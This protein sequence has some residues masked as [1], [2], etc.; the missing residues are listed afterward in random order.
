MNSNGSLK[1]ILIIGPSWLGDMVMAQSLFKHILLNHNYKVQLDVL[2]PS[3]SGTLLERMPEVN[4]YI[5]LNLKHGELGLKKRYLIGKQLR[6]KNYTEAVILP[7]SWKSA[8]I[9]FIAEIPKRIG[10]VGEHRFGLINDIRFLNKK[11][12][13]KMIE[14]YVALAYPPNYN[15]PD[16]LLPQLSVDLN[17]VKKLIEQP[18]IKQKIN[19]QLP[20][21]GLGVDAAFGLAK[22]W[23]E[24]YFIELAYMASKE[25]NIWIFGTKKDLAIK[26]DVANIINFSGKTNLLETIDLLSLI[27]LI[28]CNDSGLMHIAASLQKK[29]VAIYGPTS[30]QITPPLIGVDKFCIINKHLPC[31]PCFAR[32]C[33]LKH[34]ACMRNITVKEVFEAA[35]K[36]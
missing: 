6:K 13:F 7:N 9:P 21:L 23:P 8:L 11:S 32:E 33:P 27:D 16:L 4:E 35:K 20:I 12:H 18:F 26:E 22:C 24:E 30:E 5:E 14:H 17:S 19:P 28:V 25:F 34:H 15:L 10:W 2:A 29:I 31:S 1:K 36:L 3:W